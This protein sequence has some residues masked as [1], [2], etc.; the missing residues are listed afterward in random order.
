MPQPKIPVRLTKL[1]RI[2]EWAGWVLVLTSWILT[3]KSYQH[4]PETIATH[5]DMNGQPDDYGS[6]KNLFILPTIGMLLYAGLFILSRKP[7]LFNFPTTITEANAADA[8]QSAARALRLTNLA[9]ISGISYLVYVVCATGPESSKGPGLWFIIL[10]EAA[11]LLPVI[12]MISRQ[13]KRK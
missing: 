2:I 8:Y 4:L 13:M 11:L 3:L 10:F 6:K 7:H 5:F 12:W 1:D 9:A